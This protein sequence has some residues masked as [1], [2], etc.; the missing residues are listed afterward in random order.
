MRKA[1]SDGYE[2]H[3]W[4]IACRRGRRAAVS[5]DAG[6]GQAGGAVWRALPHHRHH[7]FQLHQLR[8]APGVRPHAVQ[9]AVAEPA[10][11]RRVDGD[12]GAGAGRVLRADAAHAAHRRQLVHGHGGRRL[13][14]HLLDR[15]RAAEARDH[16]LRRPHLQDGLQPHAGLP[17]GDQRRGHAGDAADSARR[18]FAVRRGGGGRRR[19]RCWASRRSRRRPASVRRS[20]P[21]P[22]MRR[23]AFTSS[24]PRRC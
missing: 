23:W 12:C 2:R 13:P 19:A 24:I 15:Q 1:G 14:E 9:G 6:P 20:I 10:H 16:S 17:Q 8:A 3:S 4:S 11:P 22:W 7:A 18:G 21:T 5:T